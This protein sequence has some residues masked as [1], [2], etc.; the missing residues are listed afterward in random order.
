M[1]VDDQCLF[2]DGR[3]VPAVTDEWFDDPNPA[4]GKAICRVARAGDADI[5][6]AVRAA[7]RA[8]PAWAALAGAERGRVLRRAAD[9]LRGRAEALARLESLD[10]GRPV[11]ETPTADI[12]SGA[13][14]LEYFG[15]LAASVQ[16]EYQDLGG[17]F[18]YTRREPLGVCAGIGA[19]NYPL[20]IACWKAAPALACGN[21]MVFK[22]A[23]LT[24]LT[25]NA[26]AAILLEA[27]LPAGLFN[28]VHGAAETGRALTA[29]PGVAKV[30]LTGSVATGR[31]V[32]ADAADGLKPVTMELGGK[33]P[34]IVFADT[35]PEE[36]V[37][38]AMLANFFSQGEICTNGTRVFVDASI[39]DTFV[40]RLAART[41]RLRLGD[42]LDPA[43]EVG[44]LIS[45]AHRDRVLD[46]IDSGRRE[47]ARVVCGGAPGEGPLAGG[48]WVEPTVFDGCRDD[49]TITREEIFGPV[50]A[51]L[52]FRDEAEVIE[53]ANA[54]PYGLA[55]GVFTRDLARGHRVA[56]RLQAGVCWVNNYNV[57]PVEMPFGG[58]RQ[59]GHG[60]ENGIAAVEYYTQRK[61]VYV[62]LSGV[63]CPF[64]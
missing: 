49:M 23:E 18:F 62:E 31:S 63:E 22:P 54:S 26:L 12:E 36:A 27:G 15:G 57:T 37:S 32:M 3:P 7:G 61:S 1:Q 24:P 29:N 33:S 20:Q 39:H 51:V 13:A 45:A 44:P 53:R 25:A 64:D 58:V 55:A 60:R 28:V 59:S 9:L 8:Q 40:E 19:W 10:T 5:D 43:T 47:G 38:A 46:Y 50:L 17:A 52:S 6:R 11:R 42:P 56:A 48:N 35:D 34:L 16:G 21:A 2:I 4:T 41:R 30:S 14:C